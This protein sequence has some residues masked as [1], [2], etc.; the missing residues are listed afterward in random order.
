MC[1]K[2][3]FQTNYIW[4]TGEIMNAFDLLEK[5]KDYTNC[6]AENYSK[7]AVYELGSKLGVKYKPES[8]SNKNIRD[9]IESFGGTVQIVDTLKTLD[10]HG[11]L[12]VHK[13]YDFDILLPS[14]TSMFRDIFTL[15]H[16][17]G[18]YLLHTEIGKKERHQAA[19][20]GNGIVEWEANW[21]AAGFLM[22]S[23][24]LFEF[25]DEKSYLK[26]A[27][28]FHVSSEMAENRMK[29]YRDNGF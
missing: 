21:F 6:E 5:C 3:I 2:T 26:I 7:K 19:R 17:L 12:F 16:E 10:M 29:T 18:H 23:E 14:H 1:S 13:P 27:A 4:F 24:Q 9:I 20:Y 8:L 15:A 28:A 22:P 11:S 25:K